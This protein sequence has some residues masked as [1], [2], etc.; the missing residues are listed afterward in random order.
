MDNILLFLNNP[1]SNAVLII[2]VL[3]FALRDIPS[4]ARYIPFFKKMEKI[5]DTQDKKY[6]LIEEH[7]RRFNKLDEKLEKI[8][9]NHLHELPM[10][11]EAIQ[12]IEKKID[13][14]SEKQESQGNRI[15]RVETKI[16]DI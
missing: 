5:S 15:T 1:T 10:M 11:A 14:I 16:E 6:P 3:A 12:R 2:V 8:A 7:I 9:S 13:D 4:I